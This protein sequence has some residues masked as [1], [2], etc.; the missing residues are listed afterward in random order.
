[1]KDD[2]SDSGSVVFNIGHHFS[3]FRRRGWRGI[4]VEEVSPY[5]RSESRRRMKLKA[6]YCMGILLMTVGFLICFNAA[7]RTPGA[8]LTG[9]AI[10]LSPIEA[11]VATLGTDSE[12]TILKAQGD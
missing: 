4:C 8:G 11:D 12:L 9:Q 3:R 7:R 1:M 2:S 5:E 10:T 6:L